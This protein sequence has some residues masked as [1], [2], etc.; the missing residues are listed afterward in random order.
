MRTRGPS[1]PFLLLLTAPSGGA[2]WLLCVICMA[3][4]LSNRVAS[5]PTVRSYLGHATDGAERKLSLNC[6]NCGARYWD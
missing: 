6:T 2:N 5:P 4:Y 1:G 3:S